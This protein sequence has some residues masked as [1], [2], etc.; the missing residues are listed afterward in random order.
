MG[1]HMVDASVGQ[2]H[3]V[4]LVDNLATVLLENFDPSIK[5]YEMNIMFIVLAPFISFLSR[6]F[7]H[8]ARPRFA[9]FL[10]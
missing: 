1:S 3:Q 4:V 2:G 7:I 5:F 10:P 6:H 8:Y 9:Y